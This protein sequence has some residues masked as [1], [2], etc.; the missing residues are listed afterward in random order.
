MQLTR[1]KTLYRCRF[2]TH[3]LA[4]CREKSIFASPPIRS[5]LDLAHSGPGLRLRGWPY[6]LSSRSVRHKIGDLEGCDASKNRLRL[7][8]DGRRHPYLIARC[9]RSGGVPRRDDEHERR[10]ANNPTSS[11]KD[12]SQIHGWALRGSAMPDAGNLPIAQ[13]HHCPCSQA[14]RRKS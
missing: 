3:E 2:R 1:G 8:D 4:N 13:T 12:M 9:N 14:V 11:P 7:S 10:T 6:S 5:P